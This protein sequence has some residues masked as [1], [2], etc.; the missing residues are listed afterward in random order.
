MN[1]KEALGFKFSSNKLM[2]I[3]IPKQLI[4]TIK[5]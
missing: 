3:R 2:D 4:S 1:L 5:Y